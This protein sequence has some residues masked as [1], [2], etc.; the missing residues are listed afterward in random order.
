MLCNPLNRYLWLAAVI[1]ASCGCAREDGPTRFAVRGAV[2]LDGQ[3]LK[4]GRICFLP[5]EGIPGPAAVGV[6]T[7]GFYEIPRQSGPVAGRHHVEIEADLS[8]PFAM[9]DEQ[10]YAAAMAQSLQNFIPRQPI[11][12]RY[13]R[14]TI[15]QVDVSDTPEAN[16]FDFDLWAAVPLQ[17]GR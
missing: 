12:P 17:A 5:A 2:L 16:K 10:A 7:D 11:P 4:A 9:D 3:P 6:I 1:S 14:R 13:N 8:L 15:L